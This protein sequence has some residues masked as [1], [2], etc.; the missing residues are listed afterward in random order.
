MV[1]N[2]SERLEG[3]HILHA[4]PVIGDDLGRKKPAFTELGIQGDDITG[5]FRFTEHIVERHEIS[6]AASYAVELRYLVHRK[7]V[8]EV[9]Y[10]LRNG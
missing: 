2:A 5:L 4:A 8:Y 6:E 3:N 1:G 9:I 7:P 10:E